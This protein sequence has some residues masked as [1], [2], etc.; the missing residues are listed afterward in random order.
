VVCLVAEW[1]QYLS[2]LGSGSTGVQTPPRSSVCSRYVTGL[3][4]WA[5]GLAGHALDV[6][7]PVVGGTGVRWLTRGLATIPKLHPE[8]FSSQREGW[9]TPKRTRWQCTAFVRADPLFA[10]YSV[11]ARNASLAFVERIFSVCGLM[12]TERRNRMCKSLEMC[13]FLKLN[14]N[15]C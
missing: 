6:G 11:Y 8:A 10:T 13:A 5:D 12:T 15:V 14:R 9:K 1:S 7:L 3:I 2:C 4:F